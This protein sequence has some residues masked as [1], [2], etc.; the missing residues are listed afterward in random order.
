[1]LGFRPLCTGVAVSAPTSPEEWYINEERVPKGVFREDSPRETFSVS[2]SLIVPLSASPS[3]SV[4]LK[5]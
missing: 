2:E 3:S 4:V 5:R 1:M